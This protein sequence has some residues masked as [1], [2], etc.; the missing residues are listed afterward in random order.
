LKSSFGNA[1][2]IGKM[3]TTGAECFSINYINKK[4]RHLSFRTS[5]N[6]INYPVEIFLGT[7]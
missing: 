3:K 1:Y 6:P 7:F 5:G 4:E 2:N